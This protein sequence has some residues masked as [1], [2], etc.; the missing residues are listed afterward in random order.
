M[1]LP[2]SFL[3]YTTSLGLAGFTGWQVYELLP[4]QK[5]DT[6]SAAMK[7]GQTAAIDKLTLGRGAGQVS[8]DWRYTSGQSGNQGWWEQFKKTNFLG[9]LPPPPK[10][11]EAEKAEPTEPPPP[12]V[13]PLEDIIELAA[14]VYDG[15]DEGKGALSH[16]VVRYK[17][18]AGVTP[19]EWYVRQNQTG[20]PGSFGGPRDTAPPPRPGGNRSFRGG[21]Q[22]NQTRPTA[23]TPMPTG[24]S[25]LPSDGL[26]QK[27]W[28]Q[29]EGDPRRDP[30]LWPPFEHIRLVRVDPSAESAYFVREVK[31]KAGEEPVEPA[32]EQLFRSSANVSQDVLRELN[33]FYGEKVTEN[34]GGGSQTASAKSEWIPTDETKI[35]GNVTHIGR[36]DQS[37]FDNEDKFFEK[38]YFDN[39]TSRYSNRRGI[40]VT[41]VEPQLAAKYGVA[42]GDV[43]LSVNDRQVKTKAQAV[44]FGKDEYKKG[45]RTFVTVWLSAGQE[46]ERVYQMPDK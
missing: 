38:V 1:K 19:P 35:V 41:N 43:L 17:E 30:H 20:A 39:Y 32:E 2:I 16:V 26:L 42:Q 45:V 14:L 13:V 24:A 28:V 34:A 40:Q 25:A 5:S 31:T 9:K 37:S 18:T 7:R 23:P 29:G 44:K 15:A 36:K 46:V 21:N 22:S 4:L 8:L 3:L 33:K 12:P 27:V 6:K 11:P 10:D